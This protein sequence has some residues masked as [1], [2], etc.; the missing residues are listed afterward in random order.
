M[1][2]TNNELASVAKIIAIHPPL[3]FVDVVGKRDAPP[4]A[5]QADPHEADTRKKFRERMVWCVTH[6]TWMYSCRFELQVQQFVTVAFIVQ[7]SF[8]QFDVMTSHL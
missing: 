4:G 3:V 5:F 8:L 1:N 2:I 6:D 7:V